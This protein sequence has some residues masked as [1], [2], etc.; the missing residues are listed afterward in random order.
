MLLKFS[1]IALL[2]AVAS[3]MHAATYDYG[4]SAKPGEQE[5]EPEK[6]KPKEGREG[7]KEAVKKDAKK[8]IPILGGVTVVITGKAEVL[9]QIHSRV[10]TEAIELS[11]AANVSEALAFLPGL[12][13]TVN[14]RGEKIIYVRGNDPRRVPVYLDGIPSYV[15]YDGQMDFGHFSTFDIDEI[16]VAKG[17]SS[18]IYGPNTLGGAIN[19]ITKKP[20]EKFEG[21]ALLG[22]ADGNSNRTAVNVG[23]SQ[24]RFFIQASGRMRSNGDFRM[25]SNFVPTDRE[26]GK[27]RNNSDFKDSK[28]SAKFGLVLSNGEYVLG[29]MSQKGEKGTPV[30][31]EGSSARYWRWPNWDK[32]NIYFLSHTGIGNHSYVKVRAYHDTYKNTLLTYADG[33]YTELV[34]R[35]SVSI[36]DDFTN[37][38]MLEFGTTLFKGHSLRGVVQTKRDVHRSI[39]DPA[40]SANSWRKYQDEL[41]SVGLE[42]SMTINEKLDLTIGFGLDRQ[43]PIE[44]DVHDK[45]GAQTFLQGL[46]G[47]FWKIDDQT[48]AYITIARKGKFP[49]IRDRYSMRY[50]AYIINPDLKSEESFNYDLGIKTKLFP[51]LMIEGAVFY[52]D[53]TNLIERIR[54]VQPGKDQM[55]NVGK[56]R[57]QGIE[58]SCAVKS[59][60]TEIGVYYTYLD[61]ENLSEPGVRLRGVP[62]NRVTGFAKVAPMKQCFV[63]ASLECQDSMWDSNTLRIAGYAAANLTIGYSPTNE[64]K[65]DGGF[66]N[67]LDRAYQ[68]SYGHPLPGR[69]WFANARYKF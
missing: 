4:Q 54:D 35:D 53:I 61:R 51:W 12:S 8:E 69:T 19:L 6:G 32:D 30:A 43:K 55:Q 16:Q 66:T 20:S 34:P 62:K 63:L 11:N 39:N 24:Q 5:K 25:S 58:L 56:V 41:S 1:K 22:A 7:K 23:S 3:A 29:G 47:A 65:I 28:L 49:T 60:W 17:F 21:N 57:H 45:V 68:Q 64:I 37:G 59:S 46:F 36:Y 42:D 15:P 10:S 44:T 18:V 52:S 14:S 67:I 13:F 40:N 31:T 38:A 50:D 2:I 33:T 9:E 27:R 48:Q 26:D